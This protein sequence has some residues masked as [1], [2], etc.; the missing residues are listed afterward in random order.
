M[1]IYVYI[2]IYTYVYVSVFVYV[3][4]DNETDMCAY[5]YI[6]IN[7]YVQSI[8]IYI[9]I[10]NVHVSLTEFSERAMEIDTIVISFLPIFITYIMTLFRCVC[11][12][13]ATG[14]PEKSQQ[15]GCCTG[16]PRREVMW[17]AFRVFDTN[18]DG[19]I[20]K[21]ELAKILKAQTRTRFFEGCWGDF[22]VNN[23]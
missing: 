22:M 15:H 8:F 10:Y 6:H 7:L 23:G 11:Q 21:D 13:C 20:T 2:Y 17:A 5:M 16:R 12:A 18:G 4:Y 14:T 19:V 3:K 1:Y 9:Y